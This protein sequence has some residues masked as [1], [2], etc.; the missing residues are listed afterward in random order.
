MNDSN[1]NK[2]Y[3]TIA[4]SVSIAYLCFVKSGLT[5]GNALVKS[6]NCE[7]FTKKNQRVAIMGIGK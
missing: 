3:P 2:H 1:R 7:F 6:L 5:I 4:V